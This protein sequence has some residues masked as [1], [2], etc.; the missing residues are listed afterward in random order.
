MALEHKDLSKLLETAIVAAR[1]AGQRAMEEMD[2]VKTSV[3]GGD[4]LVTE[5][6]ARCQKLIIDRVKETY[7]DHGFIGEEGSAGKLFKQEPR[8]DEKIW[9][10][11]DPIDGT[12]NFAHKMPVFC[13][14]IAAMYENEPVVGVIFDPPGDR[15]YTAFKGGESQLNGRRITAGQDPMDIFSSVALDSHFEPPFPEWAQQIIFRTRFRNFG[16]LAL[17][18]AYVACGGLVAV[19]SQTIKLWDI[20]AGVLIA[21]TAG[22]IATDHQ[23]KKLFPM[24][25]AAYDGS[26]F[27]IIAA[28]SK[29]HP[30]LLALLQS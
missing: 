27:Q 21:E 29:V 4:E 1:L 8:G 18:L 20:A 7:P 25:V 30:E 13:V 3:K 14:S 19:I 23:G 10:V 5:A 17:E 24:D 12:N 11:I 16:S 15:I 2:Y 9:W 6:D 22:A 28:N 26:A